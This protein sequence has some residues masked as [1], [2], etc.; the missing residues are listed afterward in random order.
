LPFR[1]GR[2]FLFGMT[3]AGKTPATYFNARLF[4]VAGALALPALYREARPCRAAPASPLISRS[5]VINQRVLH[6][7]IGG[8][9][10]CQSKSRVGVLH[11]CVA[12]PEIQAR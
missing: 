5:K 3:T 6:L 4:A 8:R 1:S 11:G 2:I 10:R 7:G 9:I 12:K